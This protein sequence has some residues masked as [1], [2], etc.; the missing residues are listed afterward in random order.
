MDTTHRMLILLIMLI[1]AIRMLHNTTGTILTLISI[2][3]PINTH[4]IILRIRQGDRGHMIKSQN[5]IIQTLDLN[6][7]EK[8]L[9]LIHIKDHQWL[10]II[11][12]S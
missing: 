9:E 7:I 12:K 5:S 11:Q 2:R 6:K 8:I 10:I 1:K 4:I 3:R